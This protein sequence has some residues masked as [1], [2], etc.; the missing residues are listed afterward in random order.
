MD[1]LVAAAV[2]LLLCVL[3]YSY[4]KRWEPLRRCRKTFRLP[5]LQWH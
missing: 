3:G 5:V 4:F 2:S 1:L